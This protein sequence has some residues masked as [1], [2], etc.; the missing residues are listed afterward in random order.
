MKKLFAILT[1]AVLLSGTMWSAQ[2]GNEDNG[3]KT[4]ATN[5]ASL[6]GQVVDVTTG[7]ALTGV[8]VNIKGTDVSAYTSFDGTFSV[9]GLKP[10]VYKLNTSFIS[11]KDKIIENV[12]L[13]IRDKNRVTI[14]I[15]SM[16]K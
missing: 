3:N 6:K 4:S 2:A 11:Y 1:M 5:T 7:E 16:E 12:K 9:Q 13:E 15:E 8:K 14:K 10:G